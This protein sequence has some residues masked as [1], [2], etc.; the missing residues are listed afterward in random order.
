MT[1]TLEAPGTAAGIEPGAGPVDPGRPRPGPRLLGE[2]AAAAAGQLA[3]GAGNLVFAALAARLLDPAGFAQLATF[4]ALYLGVHLPAVALS[5]AGAVAPGRSQVAVERRLGLTAAVGLAVCAGPASRLLGVSRVAVL[6]LG[7][8][9]L[10]APRLAGERGRR[11]AA[12]DVRG[13][14][15]SLLAEPAL[16]VAVGLPLVWAAGA[17]GGAAGVVAGGWVAALVLVRRPAPAKSG[18]VG[19]TDDPRYARAAAAAFVLLA[20]VQN[21]DL[22]L[23][24]R[25]MPA[26]EAAR[27]AV[28]STL[29]GLAAFAT[30]T[31]PLVLLPR[32][33]RGEPG[34]VR[35]AVVATAVLGGGA[36]LLA[37]VA[38]AGLF[39]AVFGD[40]YAPVADLAP[41][42]VLAMA[43]LGLA[44]VLVAQRCTGGR[45]ALAVG[46][47]GAA[48]SVQAALV[49]VADGAAGAANATLVATI[50]LAVAL[51]VVR[52][53]HLAWLRRPDAL[54]VAGL[55]LAALVLRLAVDRGLWADEAI[56]VDLA[57]RSFPGM[58]HQLRTDDVH[59]PLHSVILWLVVRGAG[60]SELAVRLPSMLL[61]V[62]VVPALYAAG[63][64]LY[65]RR[66]GVVAAALGV[67]SPLLVWYSQEAR[68]YSLFMLLGVVA[69]WAQVQAVR[70]GRLAYWGI[71]AAA[72]AA[73]LWTHYF[74]VLLVAVQ[75]AAFAASVIAAHRRGAG[76]RARRLAAGWAGTAVAVAV[77]VA[78]LVP[79]LSDQLAGYA[80]RR[81]G[82]SPSNAGAA[83]TSATD[84]VSLYT[85]LANGVWAMA[86]FH[87]D[88]TMAQIVALWPLGML[89]ALVALG[90]RRST[91]TSVVMAAAALPPAL[92]YVA[93]RSK[94]DLFELRYFAATAPFLVL[95]LA[96][97]LTVV[98]RRRW[99]LPVVTASV[100]SLLALGLVD[101]QLNGANPRTYDFRGALSEVNRR[102]GAGDTLLYAPSFLAPVIEYYSGQL[103]AEPLTEAEPPEGRAVFVMATLR[104]ANQ[105][106]TTARVRQELA[107]L[108]RD[109]RVVRQFDRANVRVWELR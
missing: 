59:P 1:A 79:F 5:A 69:L 8:A 97:L 71:Y 48:A 78:P 109:R 67:V 99:A 12:G 38:P 31:V 24:N 30:A 53:H 32:A 108:Q 7:L 100:V 56:S 2:Q 80:D 75:Q 96:R 101:Q 6:L 35:A 63:R 18:P 66:T 70:R 39:A 14:A 23:V 55:C 46:L 105:A 86:G 85:V 41:R 22:V 34:A 93:A 44:R 68:M 13:V 77:A 57:T 76:A 98:S 72:S 37:A 27:F 88:R 64:A 58:L 60:T 102:A 61:G 45:P 74:S 94:P 87:A 54:V 106:A 90:R 65:D 4:L 11:Y 28:L 51:A 89:L 16:R 21:L 62:A 17:A 49:V 40:R 95:L 73:L 15:T 36:A 42:Y 82:L 26:G 33:R 84:G 104:T 52:P 25:L 107:V 81:V 43:A 9:A 10:V 50:L 19:P 91:A 103:R 83:A 92:L 3:S 20:L 29:G 47:V